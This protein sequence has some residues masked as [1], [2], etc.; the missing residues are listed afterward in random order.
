[1]TR[2]GLQ[3]SYVGRNYHG[4]QIQNGT[5]QHFPTIQGTLCQA[6]EKALG[7][8]VDLIGSGRTDQGVSA[9]GQIAHM[10]I[11]TT[12]P[13]E[14]L[15]Y[16]INA[17]L[18]QDI[19]VLRSFLV[20]DEFHA[21]YSAKLKTY[22]YSVYFS[23][24][25]IPYYEQF[26]EQIKRQPNL[27]SMQ[28]ASKYFL[29]EHDFTSFCAAATEVE[30]KVRTITDITITQTGQLIQFS[31]T[32]NGF[33]YHMVRIMVGTLLEV[34]YGKRKPEDIAILLQKKDRTLAG[35]TMPAKGLLL[36]NVE[37]ETEK[38]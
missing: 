32:G 29:Q 13:M 25:T 4:W 34:G 3:I 10:D 11:D 31:I 14:K 28:Q 26:A 8:K 2:V 27:N 1:M 20:S 5:Q 15:C 37:Y 36:V 30:N 22:Q 17:Y 7:Q 35:K 38:M 21:R 12:Y 6:I 9:I 23:P 33:L 24:I 18:P 16:L 19:R